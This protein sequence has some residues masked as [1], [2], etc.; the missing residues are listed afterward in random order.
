MGVNEIMREF[1]IVNIVKKLRM[2]DFLSTVLLSK[3][4][5]ALFPYFKQNILWDDSQCNSLK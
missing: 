3:N 4:E 1:D 2:V 5:R